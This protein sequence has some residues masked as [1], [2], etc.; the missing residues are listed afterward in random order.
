[1]EEARPLLHED[2]AFVN[3]EAKN[4]EGLLRDLAGILIKKG[5][6]KDSY[7]DE[8]LTRE[9]LFPTGLAT[10]G[11]KVAIPHTDAKY[12]NVPAILIAKLKHPIVF[13][14]MGNDA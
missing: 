5:Y 1:M 12:V 10:Q 2:L 13:K 9:K 8:I 6:V 14:A 3:Y 7:G 4:R 11:V